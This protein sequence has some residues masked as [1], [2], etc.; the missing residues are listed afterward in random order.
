ME[1][2]TLANKFET[3]LKSIN[4]NFQK[5]AISN[6]DI[7][8]F[9][10]YFNMSN[11]GAS[12]VQVVVFF[13]R[14]EDIPQVEASNFLHVSNSSHTSE[15]AQFLAYVNNKNESS[16]IPCKFYLSEDNE[17]IAIHGYFGVNFVYVNEGHAFMTRVNELLYCVGEYMFEFKSLLN[18]R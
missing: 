17:V 7:I 12:E 2:I 15:L 18:H 1:H 13:D 9:I 16:N 4:I 5:R 10:M 3:H 11:K 6:G 14:N 8:A